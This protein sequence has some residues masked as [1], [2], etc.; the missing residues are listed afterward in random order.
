ML[1]PSLG[2]LPSYEV[3]ERRA[4]AVAADEGGDGERM[5]VADELRR[6]QGDADRRRARSADST[7]AISTFLTRRFG[8]AGGLAW[9]AFLLFGVVSE[10]LKTRNEVRVATTGMKE[11]KD[12]PLMT[13]ASGTT[14]R[15]EVV[16]AGD[17]IY[18]GAFVLLEYKATTDSGVVIADTNAKGQRATA[19]LY[20]PRGASFGTIASGLLEALQ[21]ARVGQRRRVTVPPGAAY[22]D[23]GTLVELPGSGEI[24]KVPGGTTIEYVVTLTRVSVPPS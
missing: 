11:V 2:G 21:G 24:Y 13:F 1:R 8:L 14:Y 4:A 18:D 5:S 19:F 7:D 15:D 10:Q 6:A 12:A 16:G 22:G 23:E 17:Q 9:T 3:M 20:T